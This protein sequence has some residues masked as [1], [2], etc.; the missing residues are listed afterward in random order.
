MI[1][2]DMSELNAVLGHWIMALEGLGIV[3]VL[4]LVRA[5]IK[6]RVISP[7]RPSRANPS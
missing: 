4:I 7:P 1:A 3:L 2:L 6:R 5:L